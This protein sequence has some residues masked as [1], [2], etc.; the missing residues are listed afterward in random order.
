M[1]ACRRFGLVA[2]VVLLAASAARAD[3]S[4]RLD[5]D[6][7]S[8]AVPVSPASSGPGGSIWDWFRLKLKPKPKPPAAEGE[9]FSVVSWN[10]Q[11][12]GTRIKAA[13]RQASE[14]IIG[15]IFA[16][17]GAKV[18]AAEE[19]AN[20]KAE[21]ALEKE[22]DGASGRWTA[23]FQNSSDAQDNAF[24]VR[25]D[26]R[27]ECGS[28]LF[29]DR[30]SSRHPA[31][32][33]HIRVGELD[34]TMIVVHLA[35]D[36][37]GSESSVTELRA[38]LGWLESYASRPGADPDVIIAGD[39]NLPTRAGKRASERAGSSEWPP[40]EDVL[41]EHR[42]LRLVPLVDEPTSR[43]HGRPANNYDHFILSGPL[44]D[45]AYVPGSAR[46]MPEEL[47]TA[48]EAQLG[49]QVSDHF[50]I[51]ARFRSSG[52][53]YDGKPIAVDGEATCRFLN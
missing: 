13:R 21:A 44:F 3:S 22:L 39:F 12:F 27:V 14:G 9:V 50:P 16:D 47:L 41:A 35:Y 42:R 5:F 8:A 30:E 34:F 29:S 2:L 40:L 52:P 32:V 38:V 48:V 28:F 31:R 10:L 37:G 53:G 25:S 23:D 18:F 11:T 49:V 17:P 36:G 19:L 24:F 33:A 6:G 43:E 15:R 4:S 45:R 7:S 26:A 20:D 1:A 51:S 46:R